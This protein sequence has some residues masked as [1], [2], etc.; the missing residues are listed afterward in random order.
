MNLNI[1]TIASL[2]ME[3]GRQRMGETRQMDTNHHVVNQKKII[4]LLDSFPALSETFV[5]QEILELQ[6]KGLLIHVF[7]LFEPSAAEVAKGEWSAS[8]PVTYVSHQSR[9]SL[10]IMAIRRLRQSPWRFVRTALLTLAHH[11]LRTALSYLCYGVFVAEQIEG[12]RVDH[13]HAHF[14]MGGASVAQIVSLLTAIPYSFTAHAYDIY[15]ASRSTLAYKMRRAHFVVTCSSYNKHYLQALVEQQ[16]GKRI[17]CIY[18]GLKLELFP[19]P[20]SV[21]R[22]TAKVPCILAVSRLVEKKGLLYLVQACRKLKDQGYTV[23]CRIVGEGPQRPQ[24]EQ[25]IQQLDLTESV[26]LDGSATHEQVIK[27][28]QQI[29]IVA[30]PCIIASNGDRDGIPNALMEALYMEIPVVSTPV[31]GIPELISEEKNGLLVP[32]Q[33]ASALASALARLLDDSA[34]CHHL[35]Q[36]GRKTIRERFDIEKNTQCLVNLFFE[37]QQLHK[38]IALPAYNEAERLS[39]HNGK[40]L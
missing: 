16:I 40:R 26:E 15:L 27:M 29:D 33:D 9:S 2:L 4:Y 31:S 18:V 1:I 13:L 5:L 20:T 21:E 37:K 38:S 39:L 12:Q 3:G 8:I 28:Y 6:R 19:A 10:L 30:L 7:S 11:N 17:H 24:L 22:R 34:L 14:A 23:T 32:P 36:A 25:A 35:G